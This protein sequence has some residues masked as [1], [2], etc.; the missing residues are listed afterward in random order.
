VTRRRRKTPAELRQEWSDKQDRCWD[1][2][3]PRLAAIESWEDAKDLHNKAPA[4]DTPCRKYYANLGYFLM[5]G[6]AAPNGA[7]HTELQLYLQLV[8]RMEARGELKPG[9]TE[10]IEEALRHAMQSQD[11]WED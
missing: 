11:R 9:E 6:F 2:F 3:Q 4:P 1:E 5:N 7:N 8:K 10:K